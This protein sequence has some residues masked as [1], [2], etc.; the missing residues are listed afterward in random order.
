MPNWPFFR[1]LTLFGLLGYIIYT[2]FGGYKY[3]KFVTPIGQV[4]V[5]YVAPSNPHFSSNH[6]YCKNSGL[7]G[8]YPPGATFPCEV[9][10]DLMF[11]YGSAPSS[12]FITTHVNVSEQTKVDCSESCSSLWNTT[13][14]YNTYVS[15]VEEYSIKLTTTFQAQKDSVSNDGISNMTYYLN[16]KLVDINGKTIATF[17]QGKSDQ[18]TISMLLKASGLHSIDE[19]SDWTYNINL[20]YPYRTWGM[21]LVVTIQLDNRNSGLLGDPTYVYSVRRVPNKK[22][23]LREMS[24]QPILDA[25]ER[26]VYDR[27]GI[28]VVFTV[29]G[30]IGFFDFQ[31]LLLTLVGASALLSVSTVVVEFFMLKVLRNKNRYKDV[32]YDVVSIGDRAE[33]KISYNAPLL[34]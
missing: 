21:L 17:D 32:K 22:Y 1:L 4:A 28:Q 30:D 6:S 26:T 31:T 12:T 18:V 27:Y 13:K 24:P 2:L 15:Q 14:I 3:A 34:D 9:W 19:V 29:I 20:K 16:G 33:S 5:D 8:P 11:V 25:T 7:P 10:D 23:L